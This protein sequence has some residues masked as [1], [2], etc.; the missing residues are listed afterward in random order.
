VEREG[1]TCRILWGSDSSGKCRGKAYFE[2]LSARDQ[3]KFEAYFARL[4]DGVPITGAERIRNL[5]DKVFELKIHK[6]RLMYFR[7]KGDVVI[8]AGFDK[9]ADNSRRI[10]K[11]IDTA[12]RLKDEYLR[13]DGHEE[14]Q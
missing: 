10:A 4:A 11:N 1:P 3:V 9:K 6:R 2:A 14:S 12:K 5:G 8:V 7:Y 13:E